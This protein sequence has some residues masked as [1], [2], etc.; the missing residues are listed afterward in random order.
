M[1]TFGLNALDIAFLIII[2]ISGIMSLRLGLIRESFAL[3]ATLIGLLAVAVLGQTVGSELPNWLKSTVASQ[4]LFLLLCFLVLYFFVI[5]LGSL[6]AKRVRS[7]K[8]R[9]IDYVMLVVFGMLRG[10]LLVI[11]VLVGLTLVMPLG[12]QSL[13]H[14]RVFELA[15]QPLTT[16]VKLL[17]DESEAAF[18]ERHLHYRLLSVPAPVPDPTVPPAGESEL[19]VIRS[20]SRGIDL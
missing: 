20:E 14:S 3:G 4:M 17:P 19:P 9:F 16:L 15:D 6:V 18:L 12:N 10:A 13:A 2:F 7:V 1:D 11:L 5:L 8:M